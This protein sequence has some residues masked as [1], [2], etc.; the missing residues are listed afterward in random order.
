MLATLRKT[1][2]HA[3]EP[4]QPAYIGYESTIVSDRTFLFA[5]TELTYEVGNAN[6]LKAPRV[7]A[8]QADGLVPMDAGPAISSGGPLRS[9]PTS[10]VSPD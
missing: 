9:S 3:Q 1:A 6:S 2:Y 7:A 5:I 4:K 10:P 8:I